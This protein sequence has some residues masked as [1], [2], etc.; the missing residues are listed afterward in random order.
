[1]IKATGY[2]DAQLMVVEYQEGEVLFNS[3][4]NEELEEE[5]NMKLN[6]GYPIGGTYFP[7]KDSPLN[8]VNVL[9]VFF[10]D[11]PADIETDEDIPTIPYEKGKIY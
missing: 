7:N 9:R 11:K 1:M 5:L 8:V 3:V 10:F 2:K 4:K 6:R